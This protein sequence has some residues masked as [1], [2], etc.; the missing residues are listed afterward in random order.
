MPLLLLPAL[1]PLPQL[2]LRASCSPSLSLLLLL[3]LLLPARVPRSPV[4]ACSGLLLLLLL[5]LLR[6]TVPTSP[7][8]VSSGSSKSILSLSNDKFICSSVH[9]YRQAGISTGVWQGTSRVPVLYRSV[10]RY[11]TVLSVN[12]FI[13]WCFVTHGYM[14]MD[15][16]FRI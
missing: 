2:L 1:S 8:S 11:C 3:L 15:L 9:T 13:V 5:L 14:N 16:Q 4:T 7:S 10:A 12:Q 6:A